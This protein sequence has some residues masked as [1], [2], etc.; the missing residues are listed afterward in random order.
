MS[1]MSG[2]VEDLEDPLLL[3]SL[4]VPCWVVTHVWGRNDMFWQRHLER[5][6]RNSLLGTTVPIAARLPLHLVAD[7]H[8]ADWCGQK[9]YI[10][11][12]AGAVEP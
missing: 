3:L 9:G 6:G 12:S 1:Y 2:T 8:H 7:E 10:A 4:G 5:L 11:L